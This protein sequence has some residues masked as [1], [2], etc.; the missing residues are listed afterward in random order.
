[1]AKKAAKKAVETAANDQDV[2]DI[3]GLFLLT[4]GQGVDPLH[5]H[6]GAARAIREHFTASV[7]RAILGDAKAAT[8]NED[9]KKDSATVLGWMA[10]V[11]SLAAHNALSKRRTVVGAKDFTKA[12][13]AVMQEHHEG[14]RSVSLGRYC[15]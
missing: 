6:R 10:A 8:W 9:W 11:G 3:V 5:V 7:G 13:E 2:Q 1:M 4:F 15:S 14:G 12:L